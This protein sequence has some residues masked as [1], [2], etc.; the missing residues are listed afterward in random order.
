MTDQALLGRW[1]MPEQPLLCFSDGVD[2]GIDQRTTISLDARH[3]LSV[4]EQAE[5]QAAVPVR[6]HPF[7]RVGYSLIGKEVSVGLVKAAQ[8]CLQSRVT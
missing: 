2:L 1:D 7:C 4:A 3:A 5:T 8:P 6:V